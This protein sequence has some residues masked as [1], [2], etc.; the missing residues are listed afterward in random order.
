MDAS[1]TVRYEDY[2]KQKSFVKAVASLL[3]VSP[4]KSRAAVIT[5][6]Y[7]AVQVTT[8]DSYGSLAGFDRA[9]DRAPDIGGSR[10]IDSA[11]RK[12]SGLLSDARTYVPTIVILLTSGKQAFGSG[13]RDLG[14]AAKPLRDRGVAI[15]AI[16]IG[17]EPDISELDEVVGELRFIFFVPSFDGLQSSGH[18]LAGK[19]ATQTGGE[20]LLGNLC[21]LITTEFI[22]RLV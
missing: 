3:D 13:A 17:A 22:G 7:T 20:D 1:H 9:V 5:Y 18:A 2:S 12:A 15:H 21:C 16:S 11:L 6:G 8:F 19:V 4:G 14:V 10:R